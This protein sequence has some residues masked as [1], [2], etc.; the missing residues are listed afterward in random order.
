MKIHLKYLP[1]LGLLL[2][3]VLFITFKVPDLSLPYFWDELGVY[4]PGALRMKDTHSIGLLPN[5][6]PPDY[7]RGHPLFCFFVYA[8]FF[9]FCGDT[10]WVGHLLS[11]LI[12]TCVLVVFY[13]FC[14]RIFGSIVALA[15]VLLLAIQPVFYAMSAII[16]PE[17]MLT[18]FIII[19][20]WAIVQRQWLVYLIAA[21]LGLLTKEAAVTVPLSAAAYLFTESI[22]EKDVL[23]W[24]RWKQIGIALAPLLIFVAFLMVQKSQNG[25]YFFPLHTQY[26]RRNPWMILQRA[27]GLGRDTLFMQGRWLLGRCAMLGVVLGLMMMNRKGSVPYRAVLLITIFYCVSQLFAGTNYYLPRYNLIV[28]PYIAVLGAY[29]VVTLAQLF[30]PTIQWMAIPLFCAAA[31]FLAYRNLDPHTWTDCHTMAYR[32]QLDCNK[33]AINWVEQQTWA[34]DTI[35]AN[36]PIFQ[37]ISD[38]RN[39]YLI[40][41][42]MPFSINGEQKT[43]YGILYHIDGKLP[44]LKDRHYHE[45]KRFTNAY[46][47]CSIVRFD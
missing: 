4:A 41:N 5:C 22:L 38:K 37:A 34:H 21:S 25:W 46:A 24:R 28:I 47:N 27:Y 39:G 44:E 6:L 29:L 45:I 42:S 35:A 36:F 9:K 23:T 31:F 43:T 1:W 7:S 32:H 17:M 2:L 16:M 26:I 13:L 18:L 8:A 30:R 10:V 20:I 11:L 3:V 40:G 19:A 15:T 12:A 14:K 33:A